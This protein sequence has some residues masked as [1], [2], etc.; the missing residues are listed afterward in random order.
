[1]R[2]INI[3]RPMNDV[4]EDNVNLDLLV[5][6]CRSLTRFGLIDGRTINDAPFAGSAFSQVGW[7]FKRNQPFVRTTISSRR[8]YHWHN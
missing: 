3:C 8:S 7:R 2:R 6:P 1:M 5:L 4:I